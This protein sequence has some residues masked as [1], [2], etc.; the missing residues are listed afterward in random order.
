MKTLA[1]ILGVLLAAGIGHAGRK[2]TIPV[3]INTT[4][5]TASGSLGSARNSV[6]STQYI[7]CYATLTTTTSHAGCVAV[8]AAGTYRSC[9][10]YDA[11]FIEA[12][13]TLTPDA[14]IEFA[15]DPA[16]SSFCTTIFVRSMSYQEPG[17]P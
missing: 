16:A 12:I 6:D 5:G 8:N 11:A 9:Y 2:L 7:G 13:R 10:T 4:A 1:A 15:W 3:S 14:H 17:V